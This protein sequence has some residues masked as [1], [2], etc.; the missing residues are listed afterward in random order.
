VIDA[1]KL[2]FLAAILALN[3]R[4]LRAI[5]ALVALLTTH[6]ASS[7]EGTF[8]SRVGTVCLVVSGQD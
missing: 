5:R 8:D 1:A 7:S 6:I 3:S 4:L 2:T